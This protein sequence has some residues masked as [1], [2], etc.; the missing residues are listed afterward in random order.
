MNSRI[1][2]LCTKEIWWRVDVR[3]GLSGT[4]IWGNVLRAAENLEGWVSLDA[5]ALAE[6][7]LFCAVNLGQPDVLLLQCSCGLLVLGCQ[8]FAVATISENQ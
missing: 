8:S 6:V 4:A 7:D 1:S 3:W 2:V 5:E